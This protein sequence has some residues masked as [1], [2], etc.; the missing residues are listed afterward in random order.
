MGEIITFAVVS[1]IIV[2]IVAYWAFSDMI[3]QQR[4]DEADEEAFER[5]R[6]ICQAN[7]D[8]YAQAVARRVLIETCETIYIGQRN[9]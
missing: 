2:A 5:R 7:F 4:Y 6:A 9:K 3:E 8:K 1:A